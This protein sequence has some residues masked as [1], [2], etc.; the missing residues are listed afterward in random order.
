MARGASEEL[1]KLIQG[2]FE[3]TARDGKYKGFG[4]LSKILSFL[5]PTEIFRG[6]LPGLIKKGFPYKSFAANGQ[7][8]NG[9]LM[10][11]AYAIDAPSMGVTGRGTI[12]LF[13]KEVDIKLLVSPFN[14]ADF[15]IKKTP[16]IRGIL[17][18]TLVS[19]PIQVTGDFEK[20]KISYLSPSSVGKKLLNITKRVFKAPVKIIKP[21]I[22]ARKK[23]GTDIIPGYNTS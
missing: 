2:D 16:I 10:I 8:Q 6:K 11:D 21:I 3:I 4:L 7:I 23:N 22:P 9:I 1:G 15:V 18:G 5:N 13:A 14:T 17:G 19:I 20:P 12:D